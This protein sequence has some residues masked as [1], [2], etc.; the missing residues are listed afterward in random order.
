MVYHQQQLMAAAHLNHQLPLQPGQPYQYIINT[1]YVHHPPNIIEQT[2]PPQPLPQ[3]G[4]MSLQQLQLHPPLNLVEANVS[5]S[6]NGLEPIETD[7]KVETEN[8]QFNTTES[9]PGSSTGGNCP[10]CKKHFI[11]DIALANHSLLFCCQFVD[12]EKVFCIKSLLKDHIAQTHK[13]QCIECNCTFKNIADLGN[14][15]LIHR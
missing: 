2:Q 4:T 7:D 12:C 1:D 6:G 14:H 3:R 15:V 5:D 11:N 13:L 8:E 10:N 9:Q